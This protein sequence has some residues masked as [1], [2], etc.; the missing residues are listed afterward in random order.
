MMCTHASF[1]PR[2]KSLVYEKQML[3]GY[4]H[5][6]CALAIYLDSLITV[7]WGPA[8]IL[9]DSRPRTCYCHAINRVPVCS[10]HSLMAALKLLA[11]ASLLAGCFLL[12]R[13]IAPAL[14]RKC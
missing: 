8:I 7:T 2:P 10:F 11:E 14:S 4:Q 9:H 3:I 1:W 5:T 12:P 13:F 6:L